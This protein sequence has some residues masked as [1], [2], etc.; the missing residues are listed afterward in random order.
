MRTETPRPILLKSYRPSNYLIQKAELDVALAPTRTRVAARLSVKPNPAHAGKPGALRL[1]GEQLE[2]EG[3]KING[4]PLERSGYKLTA[5]DLTIAKPPEGTFKLEIVTT[6]NPDANKALSGLY[7]SRGVYCTQ[8]EAQGFRRITYFLDRPDVLATYTVRIEA[9][10]EEAPILLSNGNLLERGTLAGGKRHFAVWQD[11]HPKP[12]YLFALVGG[13]LASFASEFRTASGRKV[14]L[15]IYVEPGKENRCAWAMDSLKRSMRWDEERFGLEYDLDVFNIV[16]VSDFNMGAMENKG[17]N[18]FNDSLVLA[19][20]ETATD[21][22]FG[23]IERVIAHEYF[24]NWTGNRITCRD[25]FQLCLK[26]GLT[27]FRDQLFGE[28]MRNPGTQRIAEVRNLKARQF[29]EDAG[30]LAHPVRPDRYIEINNFYTATVYEKGAELCRML[31]TL[32]GVDGFRK[33]M[34]LYFERHDGTAATV[35]DFVAAMADSSGRDLG[36]FMTWY[37]QAG[38]PEL[39]CELKY[40]AR[41]KTADLSVEQVLRATPGEA[42]K[43]PLHIPLRLGLLG[44]DGRDLPLVLADGTAVRNGLVE[45]TKRAQTF[46]FKDVSERPVPSLLRGFSA[47]VNLTIDLSDD[48]LRFLMAH[49]SDLYN[50][51]QAT[52]DY[53]ARVMI[54]AVKALQAGER[55]AKPAG[56]VTALA[57]TVADGGL[58]PGYRAQLIVPP[59]EGDLA[60]MIGT[61]V[62]P[63]AIYKARRMLRK[64]IGTGL[65]AVLETL[66]DT[67]ADKGPYS[68]LAAAA[69]RRALRNGALALLAQRGTAEDVTRVAR[70]FEKA[71]NATDEVT[72]LAILSEIK[73]PQ[74]DKAFERFHARWKGDHLMI[75]NWFAYQAAAPL[76]GTLAAVKKLARHELF[77][78]K[79][80]NK[81]RALIGTF[82]AGNPV[83]FNRPDGKGYAFVADRVLEI[84][85]FNP[86]VAAR[87][88]SAFRSW[89]T[90]EPGRRE[91]A[92]AVLDNIAASKP[93][94]S[95]VFEI[96]TKMLE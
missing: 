49:D 73:G 36:Q 3:I 69:G 4:K 6:C 91:K 59:S 31:Q 16:A 12:S 74:R 51:W 77:S 41:H 80:P 90:L 79:N 66:Y 63:G 94:S 45:V 67:L 84:D 34:D 57:A 62:D 96:V 86:Q 37:A 35:E 18:V 46:R 11:P 29:P 58:D 20:P 33:G 5:R 40:D 25:W 54:A 19:T 26:E 93:L 30:P 95:D 52:Q 72:A 44:A 61:D 22:S 60:R 39:V 82:A 43:K 8:C 28:D 55:P 13:N 85:R 23:G 17:L 9:D 83:G 53:A 81:V 56:F 10:R 70:H 76:P 21:A 32:I 65:G 87:L 75:D 38:T 89:K 24:H 50:R 27:V 68:P 48:D 42:R 14:D 7:L 64:A 71:G 15:T 92:K 2:L 47:P 78:I 88:L 1:D